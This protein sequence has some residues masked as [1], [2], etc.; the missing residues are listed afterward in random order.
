MSK[1]ETYQE[2]KALFEPLEYKTQKDRYV[3]NI[4]P[5]TKLRHG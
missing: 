3:G 4:D 5:V 1:T 2:L